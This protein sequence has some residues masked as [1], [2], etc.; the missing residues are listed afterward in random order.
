MISSCQAVAILAQTS[1]Y[2][3]GSVM[4]TAFLVCSWGMVFSWI[5]AGTTKS[6]R[7]GIAPAMARLVW[8]LS[9]KIYSRARAAAW[10]WWAYL[11]II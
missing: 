4:G 9:L 7:V 1:A 10:G 6:V 5:S 2:L 11:L 3:A 8:P